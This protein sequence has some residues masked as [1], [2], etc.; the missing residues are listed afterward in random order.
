MP[1]HQSSLLAYYLSLIGLAL[2]ILLI[3]SDIDSM[4]RLQLRIIDGTPSLL[5]TERHDKG[6]AVD[7]SN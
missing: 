2:V 3:F 5:G 6:L 4:V 7:L 1:C